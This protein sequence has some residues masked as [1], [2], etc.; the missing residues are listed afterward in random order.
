MAKYQS[1]VPNI[2]H[3]VSDR[4]CT[5]AEI[6]KIILMDILSH[7]QMSFKANMFLNMQ[8]IILFLVL[9]DREYRLL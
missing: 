7:V 2:A 6:K 3:L 5:R 4:G 1:F 8:V 9:R